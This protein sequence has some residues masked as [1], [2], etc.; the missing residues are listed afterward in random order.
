LSDLERQIDELYQRPLPEFTSARNALAKELSAAGAKADAARVKALAKPTVI[1][2]TVNHVYWR[3]RSIWDQLI[4]SGQAL[5]ARQL[6]ALSG[7]PEPAR[8]GGPGRPRRGAGTAGT[9]GQGGDDLEAAHR[10]AVADAVHQAL[11]A[12]ADAGAQPAVDQLTRM[13][14][15]ISLAVST[16]EPPGRFIELVQPA[17]FEA[18]L[19]VTISPASPGV[20]GGSSEPGA[21]AR[22][23][24]T[25]AAGVPTV[26]AP[27]GHSAAMDEARRATVTEALA[28]ARRREEAARHVEATATGALHDAELRV[29]QATVALADARA[30]TRAAVEA[31]GKAEQALADANRADVERSSPPRRR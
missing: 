28:D 10:R 1:P 29:K 26:R 11:R 17:G 30:A 16:A 19:G 14:E 25:R 24:P 3:A 23:V 9:A 12:A 8:P 21:D 18:L 6:A 4:A 31:R 20:G 22:H 7:E 15:A 27:Q 5:R 13:L 2:W